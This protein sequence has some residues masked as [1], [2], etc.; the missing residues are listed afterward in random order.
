M[1]TRNVRLTLADLLL[2]AGDDGRTGATVA[3]QSLRRSRRRARTG[4]TTMLEQTQSAKPGGGFLQR[5]S[6][7][8]PEPNSYDNSLGPHLLKDFAHDQ[9]AIWTSPA[10]L[11]LV[12]ADWLLPLGIAAGGMLATD[13]ETSKHLSNSPSRLKYSMDFSNYG[14]A[15]MA[16]AGGG[17]YL[18]GHITHDDHKR[19]TGLLGR[20]GRHQ[21]PGR[22][23]R[24]EICVW[25]GTSAAGQLPGRLLA[26]RRFVSVG[27][28]RGGVVHRKRDRA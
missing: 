14:I 28:R 17:L 18:W 6:A 4:R 12:D 2:F 15:S 3:T 25:T 10:H 8:S 23:L 24:A 19:E 20:R 5:S 7:R 11:R 1:T 27:A 16:A 21:Q 26:G 22:D 13:T 9:K